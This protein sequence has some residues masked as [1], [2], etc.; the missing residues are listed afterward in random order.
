[1]LLVDDDPTFTNLYSSVFQAGGINY[2]IASSGSQALDLA[3]KESPALILLDVM[4]PNLDGFEVLA[5]L[6][7]M[8]AVSNA[9][10]WMVTN[11][12]EQ[13]NQE[14][15]A[16]LGASD[17]LIKAQYTPKQIIDKIKS[18]FDSPPTV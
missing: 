12:G 10:I 4:M 16:N 3:A 7:Q 15:A 5:K 11:L 8:P 17:Y 9:T 18:H 6:K 13:V 2:S 14:R 1:M